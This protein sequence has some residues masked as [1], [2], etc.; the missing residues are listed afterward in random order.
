[1]SAMATRVPATVGWPN[2]T[3]GLITIPRGGLR[4]LFMTI[5]IPELAVIVNVWGARPNEEQAE[6]LGESQG[7]GQG[8]YFRIIYDTI[9]AI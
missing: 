1:M 3:S 8:I 5:I 6:P 2:L 4:T 7:G 9:R